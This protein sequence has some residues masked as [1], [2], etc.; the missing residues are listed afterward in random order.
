MIFHLIFCSRLDWKCLLADWASGL[1]TLTMKM[2]IFH[3]V[4]GW[5]AGYPDTFRGRAGNSL[6]PRPGCLTVPCW[7]GVICPGNLS[8]VM[9]QHS[10]HQIFWWVGRQRSCS[11]LLTRRM[12]NK[13]GII[14]LQAQIQLGENL[15][16]SCSMHFPTLSWG[17]RG[18]FWW[19]KF[20]QQ[21]TLLLSSSYLCPGWWNGW[22]RC[23]V[24]PISYFPCR[25]HWLRDALK[26]S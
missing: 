19:I 14:L 5:V 17:S 16:F 21:K 15:V 12:N 24:T 23:K 8:Q 25:N 9:G 20:Q 22:L 11:A 18:L 13:F 6:W 2:S 3:A 1:E 7:N 4:D 10:Q 26:P